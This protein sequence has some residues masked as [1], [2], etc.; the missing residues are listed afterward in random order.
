LTV[1]GFLA[2]IAHA[3]TVALPY[4]EGFDTDIDT[5]LFPNIYSD[6]TL[7][8][9]PATDPDNP[10]VPMPSV[11]NGV[12][13]LKNSGQAGVYSLNVM[14]DPLPAG[15]II[16][17]IDGGNK[18]AATQ[19]RL[20][21]GNN[22]IVFHPG[23]DQGGFTQGAF[24]IEGAGAADAGYAFN[25][26]LP[27]FPMV[28]TLYHMHVELGGD[29]ANNL[30]LTDTTNPNN[31]DPNKFFH[32]AWQNLGAHNGPIGPAWFFGEG[33]YDNFSITTPGGGAGL[34]ADFDHDGDV[35]S[36]DLV[37]F[38]K[39]GFGQNANGDANGDSQTNGGDFLVWQ[40]QLGMAAPPVSAVP[41]P[42]C[43]A[44]LMTGALASLSR[45]R[46]R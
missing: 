44:L 22:A 10:P 35:D 3:G 33:I 31:N 24:R 28:N 40:Q 21:L 6:F 14:P 25:V 45:Y 36:T 17:D 19:F 7:T 34:A 46:R 26:A 29:G 41:E 42:C 27:F 9:S 4:T 20:Q 23:Y 12:L 11:L 1:S 43:I 15:K 30:T 2:P 16:V 18:N 8:A 32:A 13:H 39:P 38:W 5:T 37:N